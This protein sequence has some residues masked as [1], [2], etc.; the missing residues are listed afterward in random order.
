MMDIQEVHYETIH[1]ADWRSTHTLKPDLKTIATSITEN[2]WLS[3]IV[4]QRSTNDI[5][6]GFHRWGIAQTVTKVSKRDKGMVPVQFL[7]IDSIEARILHVQMNRGRGFIVPRYLSMLVRDV[8]RSKK[9]DERELK[10]LLGMGIDEFTLLLD[11]TIL[12][13]RKIAEH[14]FNSAWV[15]VDNNNGVA[16][17]FE[18]PPNKDH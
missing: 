15:P 16:P 17:T 10:L 2:G 18:R 1:P 11:G 14:T 8:L 4:V 6:D 5:I 7:D 12:K 13:Q 3:P 9:Y